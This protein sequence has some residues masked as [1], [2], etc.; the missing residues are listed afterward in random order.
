MIFTELNLKGA[1]LIEPQPRTDERGSFTRTFCREE[2]ERRGLCNIVSQ[3]SVSRNRKAGTLRGLHYQAD[4]F[5]EAKLVR[6]SHGSIYDVIVDIRP[7]S[8]TFSRWTTVTLGAENG[9]MIYVPA[10][11]AHGF[12]TLQDDTEALYQISTNYVP[13]MAR[14]IRWND[15]S[16]GITWP[17]RNPILSGQDRFAPLLEAQRPLLGAA[18]C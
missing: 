13:D 15:P 3:C 1:Y 9:F 14:G 17:I 16:L 8:P 5:G 18:L 2:F 12:Q 4:P 7:D 6:C 10:G 11:F